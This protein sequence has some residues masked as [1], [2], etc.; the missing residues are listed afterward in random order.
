MGWD[1]LGVG[2][3]WVGLTMGLGRSLDWESIGIGADPFDCV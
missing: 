1:D 2:R 3:S